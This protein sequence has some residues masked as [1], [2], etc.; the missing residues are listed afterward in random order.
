MA[1]PGAFGTFGYVSGMRALAL[2]L[3]R[4]NRKEGDSALM[5]A[6]LS[7]TPKLKAR[8]NYLSRIAGSLGSMGVLVTIAAFYWLLRFAEANVSD[9]R[10]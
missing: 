6:I 5:S 9:L 4:A 8:A 10:H 7:Q 1:L 2:L 3:T